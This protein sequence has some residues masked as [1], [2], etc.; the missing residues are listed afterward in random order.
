MRKNW[1]LAGL[2]SVT[3]TISSTS[4]NVVTIGASIDN[5]LYQNGTGA[6]SNG[7]GETAFCGKNSGGN[8]RRMV[9][10]F[11]I[12]GNIPAGSTINSVSLALEAVMTSPG[13]GPRSCSIHRLLADW[14]EGDSDAGLPGGNGA[15]SQ[16]NDATWVHRFFNTLNWTTVGGDFAGTASAA[17]TVDDIGPYTW[18]S[19]PSMV[20]DV[21]AW[22]DGTA[23]N[24]GW[25]TK[26]ANEGPTSTA[27]SF[28][29]REHTTPFFRPVL[30]VDFDLG[31]IPAVSQWGVVVM[32]LLTL[33]GGSI[34]FRSRP[35]IRWG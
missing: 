17:T 5:T 34:A 9:I 22:L 7:S 32:V 27:M 28:A 1:Y 18:G 21:Q 20:A 24:F 2:F 23:G 33:T 16:L 30:T 25:I 12:A 6:I 8:I 35:R 29:T 10:A 31:P 13:S 4:A 14:G 15:A 11:D 3:A 26:M 19:S